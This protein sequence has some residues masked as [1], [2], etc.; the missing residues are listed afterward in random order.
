ML[1]KFLLDLRQYR[2][3][4]VQAFFNDLEVEAPTFV[5]KIESNG[6]FE[7]MIKL[8]AIVEQVYFFRNG[9]W[10][11]VQKYIMMNTK[12]AQATGGTPII[13]WIPNQIEAVLNYMHALI[14]AIGANGADNEVFTKI[15]DEIP[16][17]DE[18][19]NQQ[20]E[21]LKSIDYNVQRISDMNAKLND[22][23]VEF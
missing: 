11:F 10:Q 5:N 18:L 19:L 23:E 17:K 2:P 13:S 20:L 9:H 15:R 1:T 6:N 8:L 21:E 14:D 3:K 22:E 7:N 4:C 12:Y 16:A